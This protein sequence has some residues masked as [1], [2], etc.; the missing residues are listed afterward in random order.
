MIT[1]RSQNDGTPV[2]FSAQHSVTAA[3]ILPSPHP[4]RES[5]HHSCLGPAPQA[6]EK[7]HDADFHRSGG[8]REPIPARAHSPPVAVRLDAQKG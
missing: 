5:I 2:S 7:C 8:P 3:L 1:A 4:A 6:Y